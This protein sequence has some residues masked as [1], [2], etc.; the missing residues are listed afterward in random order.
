MATHIYQEQDRAVA[1]SNRAIDPRYAAVVA[2]GTFG[3]VRVGQPEKRRM[4]KAK[5][6]N[7]AH[8]GNMNCA[9]C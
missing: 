3:R 9:H 1:T 2:L 6:I 8:P 5:T 4:S 7:G